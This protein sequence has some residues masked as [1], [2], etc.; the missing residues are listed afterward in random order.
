MDSGKR[1]VAPLSAHYHQLTPLEQAILR[2]EQKA[3]VYYHNHSNLPA[4]ETP[5]QRQAREK[6]SREALAHLEREKRHALV[7]VQV[8][9]RLEEYRSQYRATDQHT[10]AERKGLRQA[11][12]NEKHHPTKVLAAFMRAHGRAQP[13]P[14]FTAHH[15]VPGVGR[16]ERAAMA[17]VTLHF[18]NVRINDPDNGVWLPRT[19]IDKG[20]WAMPNAPA[21]SEIHTHNYETWVGSS[22][23]D[24]ANETMLR[25]RLL[26]LRTLLR[27]GR[28]PKK[29][30]EKPD[31]T[32]GGR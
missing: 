26:R 5:E 28:Q 30:T 15:L 25:A 22:I 6:A 24:V 14:K 31:A 20:H 1:H 32:W 9:S 19:K 8:Q 27:D 17:R 16:T 21:H 4:N 18:Y 11:M 13:S 7:Q 23:N 3:K 29:I 12:A 2:F 10:R